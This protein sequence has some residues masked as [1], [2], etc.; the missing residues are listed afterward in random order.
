MKQV[1]VGQH[2]KAEQGWQ[3][4]PRK[5]IPDY[6]IRRSD[7]GPGEHLPGFGGMPAAHQIEAGDCRAH[8]SE[9]PARLPAV[10]RGERAAAQP[11]F[12][13]D[14]LLETALEGVLRPQRL[15]HRHNRRQHRHGGQTGDGVIEPDPGGQPVGDPQILRLQA[16]HI[17]NRAILFMMV[18]PVTSIATATPSRT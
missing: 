17:S 12:A 7:P 9:R 5:Q 13:G 4:E 3:A 1:I 2:G 8:P 6:R 18:T 16:D 10:A 11:F 15:P 14:D